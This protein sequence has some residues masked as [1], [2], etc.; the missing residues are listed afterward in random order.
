[1]SFAKNLCSHPIFR[2]AGILAIS[3]YIGAAINFISTIIAAR[4]LGATDFGSASM[5]IAFPSF[6]IAFLSVKSVS[7]TTRY[8]SGYK[9]VDQKKVLALC[10]LGYLLDLGISLVTIALVIVCGWALG[11]YL[12]L[13]RFYWLMVV[14]SLSFPLNSLVNTS[15]AV[16]TSWNKF[17]ALAALVITEKVVTLVCVSTALALGY[18]ISGFVIALA[19]SYAITGV[20]MAAYTCTLLRASGYTWWWRADLRNIGESKTEF[21]QF[22]GWE[23]LYVTL[24]GSISQVPVL[25]LGRFGDTEQAGFYRLAYSL[26]TTCAYIPNAINRVI[27]PSI[28]KEW[29]QGGKKFF[30]RF[31]SWSVKIGLPIAVGMVGIQLI[32][33]TLILAVFGP[34]YAPMTLGAQIILF[35]V[36]VNS[37][38]FW[39]PA[40]YYAFGE[41]SLWVK[42]TLIHVLLFLSIS[43]YI[44]K[45]WQ[46]LGVATVLTGSQVILSFVMAGIMLRKT[47]KIEYSLKSKEAESNLE[48]VSSTDSK[49]DIVNNI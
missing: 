32:L 22:L 38:F 44:I 24:T 13:E 25:L 49:E 3:Q 43:T 29:I 6:M 45:D 28:S 33:P 4:F 12:G 7:I 20:M 23:Y 10:K 36:C 34:S 31:V 35:C 40:S 42:G 15:R 11:G 1:M 2:N 8:I 39:L 17:P 9:S 41:I 37:I 46:F 30:K 47:N 16:I 48:F 18:G 21:F 26:M 14:Y 27:Y 5:V 19:S